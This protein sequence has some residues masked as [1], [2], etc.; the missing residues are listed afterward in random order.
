MN[1]SC[2]N[3]LY[4]IL[5]LQYTNINSKGNGDAP[6]YIIP[7]SSV[8]GKMIGHLKIWSVILGAR[9]AAHNFAASGVRSTH[10]LGF[11]SR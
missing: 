4:V 8:N 6:T 10:Y 7:Y 9:H 5:A 2:Y 11:R 1:C 3:E